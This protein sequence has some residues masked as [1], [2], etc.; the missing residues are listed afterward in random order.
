MIRSRRFL[1]LYP[2]LAYKSVWT[3]RGGESY[4]A[5]GG[6]FLFQEGLLGYF[7]GSRGSRHKPDRQFPRWFPGEKEFAPMTRLVLAMV[8]AMVFDEDVSTAGNK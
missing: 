1:S 7:G 6:R 3:S 5:A 8:A 2:D 4:V